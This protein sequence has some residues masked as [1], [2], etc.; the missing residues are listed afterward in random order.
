M[1]ASLICD[2]SSGLK[3]MQ[4]ACVVG[5]SRPM[6]VKMEAVSG[7]VVCLGDLVARLMVRPMV[8]RNVVNICRALLKLVSLMSTLLV[9]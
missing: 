3:V 8:S 7:R 9:L 1:V 5:T 2:E 6:L 4:M